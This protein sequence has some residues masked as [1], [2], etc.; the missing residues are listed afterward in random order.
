LQE[1][2]EVVRSIDPQ[3]HDIPWNPV[4]R[5]QTAPLFGACVGGYHLGSGHELAALQT[6]HMSASDPIDSF[7]L[8]PLATSGRPHMDSGSRFARPE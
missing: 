2:D 3:T 8:A 4:G 6:G 5:V 7:F 1:N